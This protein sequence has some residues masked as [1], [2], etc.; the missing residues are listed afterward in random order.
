ACLRILPREAARPGYPSSFTIYDSA[1]SQRL[2][3]LACREL[4]LDPKR[5]PPKSFS[6]QVAS[7]KNELVDYD[8][9]AGRAETVQERALAEAYQLYQQRLYEAGAMDFDDLIMVTVH[10]LQMF[11]EVAEHY[12]RRFRHLLVDE[13]QDTNHAQ[14]AL[15]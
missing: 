7:L 12:R 8:T 10:L 1:D 4:D 6:A 15:I 11:P 3:P 2:M 9:F 5:F 13:Y 14:Y